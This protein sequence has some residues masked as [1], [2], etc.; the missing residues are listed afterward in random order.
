MRDIDPV[1][2][3]LEELRNATEDLGLPERFDDLVWLHV[4]R[5]AARLSP[6][7]VLLSAALA[8]VA[9]FALACSSDARLAERVLAL[10]DDA[11]VEAP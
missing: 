3:R 4:E 1:D 6:W 8:A 10:G 2:G 9:S 7:P 5:R 11:S